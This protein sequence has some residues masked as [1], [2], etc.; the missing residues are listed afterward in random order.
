MTFISIQGTGNP[1]SAAYCTPFYKQDHCSFGTDNRLIKGSY[2]DL[3]NLIN[4]AKQPSPEMCTSTP[5][6]QQ[7]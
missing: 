3:L 2:P 7:P 1:E 4:D 5:R 6:M